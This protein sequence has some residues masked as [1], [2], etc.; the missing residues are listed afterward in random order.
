[1]RIALEID[2]DVLA[3]AEELA[4]CSGTTAGRVISD[5][6]RQALTHKSSA[7]TRSKPEAVYGFRPLPSR[8][9]VITNQ[10]VDKLRDDE[11]V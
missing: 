8:S 3:A 5:L 10:Q 11:G 2:N 7:A 4:R 9:A 6:V 1:M